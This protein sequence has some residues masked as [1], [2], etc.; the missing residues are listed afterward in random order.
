MSTS[1]E[2][3]TVAEGPSMTMVW[4]K[5]AG[6]FR[7][8]NLKVCGWALSL[9]CPHHITTTTSKQGAVWVPLDDVVGANAAVEVHE[10]VRELEV[11][12]DSPR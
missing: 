4:P 12:H 2:K 10:V 1:E 8:V 7:P 9:L 3:R 11:L 6:V 5:L